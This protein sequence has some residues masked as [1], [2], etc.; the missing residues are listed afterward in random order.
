LETL[1]TIFSVITNQRRRFS[2]NPG[3]AEIKLLVEGKLD[4]GSL[5]GM[6]LLVNQT[7]WAALESVQDQLHQHFRQ[8]IVTKGKEGGEVFQDGE[9]IYQYQPPTTKIV[10]ETGAGDSFA[11]GCIAA[12]L[13]GLDLKTQVAW[14]QKNATSVIQQQGAKAGL[15]TEAELQ[16]AT[17][18]IE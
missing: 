9:Q 8:I 15:L 4:L 16:E 11:V 14:G 2:W 13:K 1:K 3:K 6:L 10:N 7:E 5:L 18:M 17:N 12:L